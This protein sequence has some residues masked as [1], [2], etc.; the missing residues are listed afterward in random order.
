M[1]RASQLSDWWRSGYY[2]QIQPEKLTGLLERFRSEQ[3][4]FATNARRAANPPIRV[5][6]L[7]QDPISERFKKLCRDH[8]NSN[9]SLR[10]QLLQLFFD[11]F[12]WENGTAAAEPVRTADLRVRLRQLLK[13]STASEFVGLSLADLAAQMHCSTRHLSRLIRQ[14]LGTSLQDK[15]TELRLAKACELLATS[16]TKVAEVAS[17]CEYQ[18]LSLFGLLFKRRFG[19]SPGKWRQQRSQTA[20]PKR[21]KLV[22]VPPL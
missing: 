17:T 4:Q 15:Q 8:N 7:P 6:A 16:D 5:R 20:S 18:S 11:L 1:L 9:C 14:E 19:V 12:P 13:Q 2:L 22:R 10:L 3:Q 21:T